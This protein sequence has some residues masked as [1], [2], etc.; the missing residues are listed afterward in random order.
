MSPE[1]TA[2]AC[3]LRADGLSYAQI[4]RV[5]GVYKA[6]VRFALDAEFRERRRATHRRS[7]ERQLAKQAALDRPFSERPRG[8]SASR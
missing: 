4:G 6:T 3:H 2:V 5:L 1:R 8:A 7:R